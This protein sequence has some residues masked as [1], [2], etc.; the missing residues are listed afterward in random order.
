MIVAVGEHVL[1]K[2]TGINFGSDVAVQVTVTVKVAVR[3]FVYVTV[4]V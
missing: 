4:G 1:V 3:L 2:T